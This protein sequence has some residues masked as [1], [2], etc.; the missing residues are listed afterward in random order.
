M[1]KIPRDSPTELGQYVR[2]R[3]RKPVGYLIDM[4]KA[5]SKFPYIWCEV[6]WN[7]ES[8]IE[9]KPPPKTVAIEELQI[10]KEE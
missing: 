9:G 3:N 5:H 7:V 1:A 8:W 4:W 2:L 6:F 10:I